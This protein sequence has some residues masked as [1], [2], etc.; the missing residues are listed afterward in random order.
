MAHVSVT[1]ETV[2]RAIDGD[3]QAATDI[4]LSLHKPATITAYR[5][6]RYFPN[7]QE[8]AVQECLAHI[9]VNLHKFHGRSQFSTW[10]WRVLHNKTLMIMR[11]LKSGDNDPV[12]CSQIVDT[13]TGEDENLTHQWS[14]V[15]ADPHDNNNATAARMDVHAALRWLG[16]RYQQAVR[17][18]YIEGVSCEEAAAIMGC[19][20]GCMKSYTNRGIKRLREIMENAPIH[21]HDMYDPAIARHPLCQRIR[22]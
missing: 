17:L 20:K 10:A 6:L 2:Q 8:D 7:D 5:I 11:R 19:T 1:N 9:L 12:S 16:P 4:Y 3:Q 21:R 14:E 18:R 15:L 22:L 13:D